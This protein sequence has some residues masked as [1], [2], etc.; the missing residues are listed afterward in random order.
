MTN[1]GNKSVWRTAF[2]GMM[3]SIDTAI[4]TLLAL[5]YQIFFN[6]ASLQLLSGSTVKYF[7]NRIQVII[8]VFMVFKLMFSLL[9]GIVNPDKVLDKKE[10]M[11]T[12]ITRVVVSIT[13][14][15]LIVPLNI[16]GATAG[17]YN[18]QLNNNGILFGTLYS[19]QDRIL[20]N[21]TLGKLI[22]G[23]A[24]DA[25]YTSTEQGND[26]VNAA[27]GFTV[28]I[29]K[30][31][32]GVNLKPDFSQTDGDNPE[33]N[34][35][36]WMVQ[37]DTADEV[38]EDY[39]DASTPDAVLDLVTESGKNEDNEKKYI[40]Y[41]MPIVSTIVGFLFVFVLIGAT[42]DIAI[43][44]IK[45]SI[46]RILA[47]IP[48]IS[49]IDPKSQK[50][51]AF[52]N[53]MKNLVST[54]LDLFVYVAIIYFVIFL[55][56]DMMKNGI[57]INTT[58]GLAG[59]LSIV[60]IWLGLFFFV[61][62]TPKFIRDL[63]G[64]KST[65]NSV[66]LAGVLGGAAALVGG[67]GLRGAV[68]GSLASMED[69]SEANVQGKQASSAWRTGRDLSAQIRT[70]DPKARGGL[71]GNL[72]RSAQRSAQQM[73]AARLL[74][75]EF[76]IDQKGLDKSK[77]D[78]IT[79]ENRVN[80]M[81]TLI[82]NGG[83][84]MDVY[85]SKGAIVDTI[86]W[87]APQFNDKKNGKLTEAAMTARYNALALEQSNYQKNKSDYEHGSELAKKYGLDQTG[88]EKYR[89]SLRQRVGN[90][91]HNARHPLEAREARRPDRQSVGERIAGDNGWKH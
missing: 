68:A 58:A 81:K 3:S 59:K 64:I 82:E 13:M 8:G 19:L 14:L 45:L 7:F 54:Y 17:S 73:T 65:S 79:S 29:L 4:Y 25:N 78:M 72:Q 88:E 38:I 51:G 50:D 76:D 49:Y 80:A 46:L 33:S 62:Q 39:N 18:A 84:K 6:V 24:G 77:D 30:T 23:T 31:F 36:N 74:K 16:P 26:A 63:L 12:I 83:T 9:G 20:K 34:R 28:S 85:N 47:P 67:A 66:G 11:G 87:S 71:I 10:G 40:L 22:L 53:W 75:R 55:I 41:Y 37:S 35:E 5:I 56:S 42:L 69:A 52:G 70:G 1:N 48:I 15:T 86:D 61:R 32:V 43:R 90:T 21:N 44:A 57:I 89:A 2:R 27:N 60:F 91:F